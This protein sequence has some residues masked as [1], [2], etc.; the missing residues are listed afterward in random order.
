MSIAKA[1][2][3]AVSGLTAT[4][5]GTETVAAN[6]A[7]AMTPGY[8]RREMA[9]SAQTLGGS[10]GGVRIDGIARIVNA[11]L[12]AE[13]RSA[14]AAR[15]NAATLSTY[16]S[17]MEEAIGIAGDPGSLGAALTGFE[18]ALQS[19]ASRPDDEVRLAQ[20]VDA[21]DQLARVLNSAS[22]EVQKSRSAAD[23]AISRDVAAL[24][25]GLERVAYL[26]RRI[27]VIEAE[28][29]DSSSLVDQRQ[30]LVDDIAKIVPVQEVA[31]EGG[32]IALFT[33]SGAVLLDGSRPAEISFTAAH[34][35]SADRT[36][37]SGALSRIQFDGAELTESQMRLF[38]GGSLEANFT[39]RDELAPKLQND[40]DALSF[41][42][43][44]RLTDSTVDPT[45]TATSTGLFTDAGNR[46]DATSIVGLA[47]RVKVNAAVRP[48]DGGQLW[49]MRAGTHAAAPGVTGDNS[50]LRAMT[51]AL[52]KPSGALA[53]SDFEGVASLSGRF[54][55]VES[56][57]STIRVN[58]EAETAIRNGQ[59]DTIS[60]R[61]MGDGV[62]SDAEMQ[63]LLQYEQ[64]YA[65]NAR[66]IQAVNDMMDQ[67]LRI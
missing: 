15:A 40:L 30:R 58:A 62:D 65:A 3:N 9:V 50:L 20:A 25:V 22:T 47:G 7:N 8:A 29:R 19:A 36:V 44:Q 16:A 33:K 10:G 42:L 11:S 66:V 39:I 49:R 59:A 55:L 21:A 5:R 54:A 53:G 35:I 51:A 48:G 17:R 4:A 13:A 2:S 26:N 56:R 61:F 60:S 41:D 23:Q 67:L 43:H 6:L 24:N 31:R 1:L 64:A 14:E 63:K 32:K 46:A 37:G 12:M 45:L 27:A 52:N 34:E 18:T 38:S 57:V 28:G